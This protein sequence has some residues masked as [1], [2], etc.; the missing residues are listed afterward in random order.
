MN[1]HFQ[2]FIINYQEAY[3]VNGQE[4]QDSDDKSGDNVCTCDNTHTYMYVCVLLNYLLYIS[5]SN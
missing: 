3:E 4:T 5:C 2:Q 1:E